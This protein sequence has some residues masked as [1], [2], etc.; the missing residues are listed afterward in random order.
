MD[1]QKRVT[2]GRNDRWTDRLSYRDAR[3]HLK[4]VGSGVERIELI[5]DRFLKKGNGRMDRPTD[6]QT[7]L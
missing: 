3:M 2:D 7:L 5:I 6:G 1:F 4:I